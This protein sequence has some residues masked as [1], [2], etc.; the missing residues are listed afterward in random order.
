MWQI[1]KWSSH[2]TSSTQDCCHSLPPEIKTYLLHYVGCLEHQSQRDIV[3]GCWGRQKLIL[4]LVWGSA[5]KCAEL[6]CLVQDAEKKRP[7][8]LSWM[9]SSL[10]QFGEIFHQSWHISPQLRIRGGGA[11]S[12]TEREWMREWEKVLDHS[13]TWIHFTVNNDV[14]HKGTQEFL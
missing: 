5:V 6:P 1:D 12:E 9:E 4:I 10:K 13:I 14:W 11:E 7:I 8:Y 3:I 2:T